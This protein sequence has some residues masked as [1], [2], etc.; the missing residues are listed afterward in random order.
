MV[1]FFQIA[2]LL[3]RLLLFFVPCFFPRTYQIIYVRIYMY[4]YVYRE[5]KVSISSKRSQK[6]AFHPHC[7]RLFAL[8]Q[9]RFS[10]NIPRLPPLHFK[11]LVSVCSDY[12]SKPEEM[13]ELC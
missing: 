2:T 11:S 1:Y 5:E 7:Q 13:V 6:I 8:L 3:T 12:T 10:E 4:R 9:K